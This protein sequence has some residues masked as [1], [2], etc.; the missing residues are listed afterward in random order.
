M[1]NVPIPLVGPTYTSRSL[2]VASQVTKNFYIEV[3]QE[4]T[5]ITS[6][7]PFPGLKPFA[8]AGTGVNRGSGVL[9]GVYYTISGNELYSVSNLGVATLIGG[10]EGASQCTLESDG[11]NLVI[12]TKT[13]KPY[14]YDGTTL[15]LGTDADLNNSNTVTYINRRV[16]YDGDGD[17]LIFADLDD[18]L[19]V[20][21][22]NVTFN[23]ST[24]DD[25]VA[26]ISKDSQ[27]YV[28]GTDS[29]VPYYNSGTGNPPYSVIQ[30][31]L[32]SIG[33]KAVNSI[34]QNKDFIYFLGSDLQV[35]RLSGIQSQAI[36][37]PSIGQAIAGYSITSNAIG[38]CFSFHNQNFYMLTF[39]GEDTW[40]FSEGAG[41]TNLSFGV[42]GDPSLINSCQRVYNKHLVADRRNGNIYELDFDTFTDNGDTIIRQ[43][44]TSRLTGSQLG[45]AGKELF[46]ERLEIIVETGVGLIT[47]QGSDPQIMM[48]YSDDGGRSWSAERWQSLGVLGEYK[49]MVE[50]FDLGAFYNRMFR[51]KV[52][53]PVKVVLISA[54]A[55]M[56]VSNG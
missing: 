24:P 21:S 52:S 47:G 41:W 19:S 45:A 4:A 18:P 37:N 7:Q 31:G 17:A 51:F 1:P 2:S 26:V 50:W 5:N 9:N 46:M 40:L 32:Q 20:N 42:G 53:D 28:F 11:V 22:L 15:T 33:T 39:P 54:N 30:N 27:L 12:T 34:S 44:D 55:D 48:Q 8:V 6:F 35:Y 23:D 16:V 13:T 3:G 10:I 49:T 14:T 36:G 29:I 43:R 56:E 38:A 25:T